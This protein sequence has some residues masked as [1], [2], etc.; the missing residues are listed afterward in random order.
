[1]TTPKTNSFDMQLIVAIARRALKDVP[2][3]KPITLMLD[4]ENAHAE[5]A[6]DLN[7]LLAADDSDFNHDVFGIVN[8]M[9]RT[10]GKL[11]PIFTPRFAIKQ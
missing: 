5:S 11:D 2:N 3:I 8:H 9:D 10:T 1:M 4:L 7:R 6:L